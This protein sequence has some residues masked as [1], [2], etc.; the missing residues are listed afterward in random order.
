[1]HRYRRRR[2]REATK[3]RDRQALG[4]SIVK[5]P[6]ENGEG[7]R[8][9]KVANIGG[10]VLQPSGTFQNILDVHATRYHCCFVLACPFEDVRPVSIGRV[11]ELLWGI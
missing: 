6:G 2:L 3:R 5:L 4:L 11:V 10:S 9:S 1:M 7:L 8:D